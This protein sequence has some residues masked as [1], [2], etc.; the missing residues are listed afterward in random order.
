MPDEF[1][2]FC[3]RMAADDRV[4][5]VVLAGSMAR[6]GA[7]TVH[8][9]YDVLLIA[10]DGMT[11]ALSGESRRDSTMDVSVAPLHEFRQHALAGS[12]S[13]WDRYTYTYAKV[14][15]DTPDGLISKLVAEK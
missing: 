7:A 15:K 4:L 6:E 11:S 2:V 3:E 14:L 8:S 5:G 12:A 13:E 10:A 1:A 9:D